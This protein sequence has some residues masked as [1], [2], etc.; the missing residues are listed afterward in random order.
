MPR[1]DDPVGRVIAGRYRLVRSVGA[2]GMGRVWLAHD[3]ELACDVAL[4]EIT[5]PPEVSEQE[6]NAR[7]ARARGEARHSAR[8]RSNPHVVTIYDTVVD[9]GLPWI[10][11]EYVPGAR[12]LEA[13]VRESGTLSPDDTAGLGLALLD[14]LTTGHQMGILHRDVKPSNVLLTAPEPQGPHPARVGRVLLTDYGISLQQDVGEPRLT[15]AAGII[16]TPGFLAPERARGSEPT[17]ASDLFSLGATLYFAVEGRGPFDRSSAVGTLAALLT[18]DPTPPSRA[19]SLAPVLLKL[20][21]KDPAHRLRADDVA[22]LLCQ[23]TSEPTRIPPRTIT[24]LPRP[25]KQPSTP[26]PPPRPPQPKPSLRLPSRKSLERIWPF[27]NRPRASDRTPHRQR[28]RKTRRII[29]LTAAGMLIVGIGTWAGVAGISGPHRPSPGTSPTGPIM[30][31][32]EAVGLTQELRPGDCVK[33]SWTSQ[34]FKGLPNLGMTDCVDNPHDGQVINTDSASS[35][36]DAQKNGGSRCKMLLAD[37]V[38]AMA[39]AR[40]Y[41]LPPSKQ[42]WDNGVHDTACLIFN[43]TVQLLGGAGHFRKIGG[44]ADMSVA[45]VGDCWTNKQSG[46]VLGQCGTP[47]DGQTAGFVR[48]PNAMTYK[49]AYA[50]EDT[51]CQNK[52]A[53]AYMHGNYTTVG[54]ITAED[55]WNAGFRYVECDVVSVDGKNLTSSVVTSPPSTQPT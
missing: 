21:A 32:G 3:E 40:S 35:L 6:L 44:S 42:G 50:N 49:A 12:D 14:A 45:I 39:D 47:H 38:N 53:S 28:P 25:T 54:I 17:P 18:E 52:Y 9:G 20:L 33:A 26:P 8:L 27:W 1:P 7:I 30:P 51:L 11:M 13:V 48:P 29:I 2:G 55:G 15:T 5:V 36:D 23:L 22:L 41:A 34:K 37:T 16:G 24:D 4:K 46:A 43:K 31:Y 19:G 10:V